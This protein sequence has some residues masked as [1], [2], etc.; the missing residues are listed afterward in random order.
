M[1]KVVCIILSVALVAS[2]MCFP[3]SALSTELQD[4]DMASSTAIAYMNLEDATEEVQAQII[5]A[6]AEIIYSQ[7]WVADGLLG[8]VLD[9][10]GDIIE[11]VPQFSDLFPSNWADPFVD[12]SINQVLLSSPN[13]I[14]SSELMR[15]FEDVLKL[16]VPPTNST[17][18]A[19][20]QFNTSGWSGQQRYNITY[21]FTKA[22]R[23]Y[24]AFTLPLIPTF[25]VGYTNM[26]TGRSLG[27]KTEI[28]EGYSFGVSTP[29]GVTIAVRASMNNPNPGE[30]SGDWLVTVDSWM[31]KLN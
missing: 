18:P 12:T 16:S 26:T 17:S 7:S 21:V 25:N 29:A 23:Q 31:T 4:Q 30:T 6:R 13:N 10:D 9:E 20:H 27:W 19:F 28:Q 2:I 11:V 22:I 1:K 14:S 3:A 24:P 5:E 15:L 8:Y